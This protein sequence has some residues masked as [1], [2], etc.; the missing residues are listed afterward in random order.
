MIKMFDQ[1]ETRSLTLPESAFSNSRFS[2]Y[3]RRL[4]SQQAFTINGR[5][6]TQFILRKTVYK[7]QSFPF[8]AA[9]KKTQ[10]PFI[11]R[12]SPRLTRGLFWRILVKTLST[13]RHRRIILC[14]I[15]A[16]SQANS[17]KP[18]Y[19]PGELSR[20]SH[21]TYWKYRQ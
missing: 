12:H 20:K 2:P 3:R 5:V 21:A 10:L 15:T 19:L 9:L 13:S 7:N 17:V 11:H 1:F 8:M 18:I 6:L 16:P 14:N 4:S